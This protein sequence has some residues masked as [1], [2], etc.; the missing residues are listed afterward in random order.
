MLCL[1]LILFGSVEEVNAQIASNSKAA[2]LGRCVEPTEFMRKNHM[3]LLLHQRDE[4]VHQGV[5]TK[6]HSLVE[7]IACHAEKD[8]DGKFVSI[9]TEGQFC[10]GCHAAVA[11]D[12]DCFEC[13]AAKPETNAQLIT[14]LSIAMTGQ[15]CLP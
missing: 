15:Y 3:E 13:H 6:K 5:R 7:C 11:V 10:Q 1:M 8:S 14:H 9:N 12:M 4:T 2:G